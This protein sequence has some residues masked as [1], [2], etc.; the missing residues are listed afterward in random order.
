MQP[1]YRN[2]RVIFARSFADGLWTTRGS[3][4]VGGKSSYF[5]GPGGTMQE[6]G[7]KPAGCP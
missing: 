6:A 4:T 1:R 7:S 3:G 5:V 2:G